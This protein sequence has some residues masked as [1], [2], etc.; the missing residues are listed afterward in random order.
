MPTMSTTALM[1]NDDHIGSFWHS[2]VSQKLENLFLNANTML[3]VQF[4]DMGTIGK[5]LNNWHQLN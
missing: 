4:S 1:T 5:L 2:Q 3:M